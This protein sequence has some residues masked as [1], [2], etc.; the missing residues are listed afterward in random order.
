MALSRILYDLFFADSIAY[1]KSYLNEKGEA[2]YSSIE[3]IPSL[4]LIQKHLDGEEVLGA[5]TVNPGDTVRWMVWDI[6]SKKYGLVKAREIAKILCD[7]L[8]E[9]GIPYGIEFSGSKGYHIEIFFKEKVSAEAVKIAGEAI[10]DYLGLQKNG[11]PHVEVFP[12]QGKLT[13]ENP[14]GNLLRL[15]LGTH[16]K[17]GK[18]AFF[19][20]MDLWEEGE[21]L[22]PEQIFSQKIDLADLQRAIKEIEPFDKIVDLLFPYWEA[23]QRHNISL[24]LSG[25]LASVGWTEESVSELIEAIHEKNPEGNLKDQLGT[26]KSTFKKYYDGEKIIG[27]T[28][29]SEILPGATM[30]QLMELAGRSSSPAVLQLVDR[31]RLSKGAPFMKVRNVA[32]IIV[33]YFKEMGRLV[34]DSSDVYWL[35]YRTHE[36]VTIGTPGWERL[37]HNTFGVNLS[38][39]FG[40]QVVESVRHYSYDE[41]K[42]VLVKKRSHWDGERLYLNLGGPEVYVLCGD[43]KQRKI[44]LNGDGDILFKNFDDTLRLPNLLAVEESSLSPWHFLTNDVNFQS[45]SNINATPEQQR[46]L[47]KAWII[48][49]FFAETMPTRPILT[50]LAGSGSGKTT[51]A[52]RILRFLEGPEQDVLGIVND[53]PDSLRSS[54]NVHKVLVLD[55]LEKTKANWLTDILNRIATGS[56]IELR[57]LHTT[58]RMRKIVPDCYVIITATEMPFS[59]ETVFTRLL[60]IELA[61]LTQP[62]PEYQIQVDLINNFNA[63]W[64]GMLDD[65]DKVVAELG[66]VKTVEA[67]NESR[68]ADFTVFC[69]RIKEVEFLNKDDLMGGL[70]SLMNRQKRVLEENSPFVETLQIWMRTRPEGDEKWMNISEMFSLLQ[71]VAMSNRVEWRW[72]SSQGLAKHVYMLESQLVQ[73][74]GMSIRTNKEGGRDVRQYRFQRKMLAM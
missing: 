30:K 16:K 24:Y 55:N 7:F 4:E 35:N 17:T 31:E 6:D 58:N 74:F 53:K 11:D 8:S 44:I 23:G 68:L 26:V 25:F 27:F 15:P 56:H 73:N 52:R 39:S 50:F 48:S 38:E 46:E 37:M 14:L 36:L 20:S 22:D 59:E 64:K 12:K 32:R 13:R 34:R 69:S 2:A 40:R 1:A 41:A 19:V 9:H 62:R 51:T 61:Q 33:S 43:P 47:L 49:I 71:K 67:P 29:L 28:G 70:G 10:R 65:L 66:R 60:P 54:M 45:G 21:P 18:S 5:Y 63:L 3:G 57:E 42:E 72:T